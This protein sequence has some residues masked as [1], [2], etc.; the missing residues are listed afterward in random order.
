[1]PLLT[2]VVR[3]VTI[4]I[5]IIKIQA[6]E[7][8]ST[9]ALSN[10]PCIA[11]KSTMMAVAAFGILSVVGAGVS[12]LIQMY[13]VAR[14]VESRPIV[15][16]LALTTVF[17]LITVSLI[18]SGYGTMFCGVKLS[19]SVELAGGFS[20]FLVFFFFAL[21]ATFFVV[22]YNNSADTRRTYAPVGEAF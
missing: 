10:L 22:R 12:I 15:A 11:Q 13:S 16:S 5:H 21:V 9:T 3:G 1:M 17:S 8:L 19:S 7:V 4:N 20:C 14:S 6:F 2:G 18:G